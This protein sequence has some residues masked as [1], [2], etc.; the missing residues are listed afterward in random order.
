MTQ[1]ILDFDKPCYPVEAGWKQ[2]APETSKDAAKGTN[3]GFL[4]GRVLDALENFGPLT[5]DECAGILKLS[6]LSIRPRFTELKRMGRIFDTGNRRRNESGKSA[7]VWSVKN[8]G[9]ARPCNPTF[10]G[11]EAHGGDR[12]A[13][14][15]AWSG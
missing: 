12:R 6:V 1:A 14:S 2:G 5:T 9:E 4:R 7:A 3:A 11:D 8:F 13:A 10:S 15:A